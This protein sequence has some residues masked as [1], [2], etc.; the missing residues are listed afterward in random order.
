M[1]LF[2]EEQTKWETFFISSFRSI[3]YCYSRFSI[4][5]QFNET[6]EIEND[7]KKQFAF[8]RKHNKRQMVMISLENAIN[9]CHFIK[10]IQ[11]VWRIGAKD[12]EESSYEP[13][14]SHKPPHF[15]SNN[16]FIIIHQEMSMSFI[17]S[18]PSY[19]YI[20]FFIFFRSIR[21]IEQYQVEWYSKLNKML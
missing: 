12:N 13:T 20:L 15:F 4:I 19:L 21:L 10:L 17:V 7:E 6:I 16:K 3:L 18:K 1:E 5:V 2:Y 8:C 9:E 11:I 14:I